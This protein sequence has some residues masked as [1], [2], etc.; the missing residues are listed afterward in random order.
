M[1]LFSSANLTADA[2]D[3]NIELGVLLTGGSAPEEAAA[4]VDGLIRTGVLQRHSLPPV[5]TLA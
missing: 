5:P 2:F 1:D 4:H 3:I